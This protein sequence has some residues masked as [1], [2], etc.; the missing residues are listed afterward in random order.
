MLYQELLKNFDEKLKKEFGNR[1]KFPSHD[2]DKVVLLLQIGVYLYEYI[3]DWEKFNE[4]S[5]PEKE[6][7]YS[8]LNMKNITDVDYMHGK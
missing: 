6:D 4:K 8:Y 2:F 3:D 7:F 5:L 1:Y